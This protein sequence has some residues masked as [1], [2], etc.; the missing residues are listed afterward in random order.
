MEGGRIYKRKKKKTVGIWTFGLVL[1]PNFYLFLDIIKSTKSR[2]K[3]KNIK[4]KQTPVGGCQVICVKRIYVLDWLSEEKLKST[5]ETSVFLQVN[6]DK[7]LHW[8]IVEFLLFVS[9]GLF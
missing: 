7:E 3:E 8:S 6:Q 1:E 9:Y 4:K 5:K 2:K